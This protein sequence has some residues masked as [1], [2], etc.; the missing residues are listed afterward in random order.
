MFASSI[1]DRAVCERLVARNYPL[2]DSATIVCYR[3]LY[4]QSYRQKVRNSLFYCMLN[5]WR[6]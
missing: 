2:V 4:R 3:V 1:I 6:I 5:Y